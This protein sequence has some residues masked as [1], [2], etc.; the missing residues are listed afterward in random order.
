MKKNNIFCMFQVSKTKL[1]IKLKGLKFEAST[2]TLRSNKCDSKTFPLTNLHTP[3]N[4]GNHNP[5]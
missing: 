2:T 3:Y 4:Y 1:C 5:R